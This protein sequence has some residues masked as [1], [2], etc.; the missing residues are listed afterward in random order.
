MVPIQG[1]YKAPVEGKVA[2]PLSQ[3]VDAKELELLQVGVHEAPV[4]LEAPGEAKHLCQ[5][6]SW[7]I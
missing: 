6:L 5:S 1:E 4:V 3:L 2:V 7:S